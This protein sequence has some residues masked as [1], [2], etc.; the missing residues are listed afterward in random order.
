MPEE[1]LSIG[2]ELIQDILHRFKTDRER[3]VPIDDWLVRLGEII[4]K[5]RIK[6]PE[7]LRAIELASKMYPEL[8]G[9]EP[10]QRHWISGPEDGT[11]QIENVPTDPNRA[12]DL[13]TRIKKEKKKD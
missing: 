1:E 12:R 6:T 8:K 10:A 5:K 4:R 3:Y 2:D 13:L 11:L 7:L 9:L